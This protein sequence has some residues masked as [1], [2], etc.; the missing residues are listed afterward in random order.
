[1]EDYDVR[2][3]A[4][5][6]ASVKEQEARFE[7]LTRALEEERRN[8]TLQLERANLPSNPPASQ[9]LAWQQVV[10]QLSKGADIEEQGFLPR[11]G[12][13][14]IPFAEMNREGDFEGE[15]VGKPFVLQAIYIPLG[16]LK[17]S[18]F[19]STP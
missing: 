15:V 3:A 9:P 13:V 10:I 17:P 12:L 5:I 4:S 19:E 18:S 7:Q 16:R 11:V 1:M 14:R 6:L 8:V 2:S